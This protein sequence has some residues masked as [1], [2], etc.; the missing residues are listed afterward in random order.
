MLAKIRSSAVVG[1]DALPVTVEV[2]I[3]YGLPAFST[4]GLA[5]GAVRESRERVKAAIKNSGY[6]FP[7]RRITVNLAPA[8][9]KKEGAGYDLPMALGIL[10]ASE[11]LRSEKL[12]NYG[13]IGELSL[14]GSI[15]PAKGILPMAI[16]AQK[17]G[18]EG[19]LVPVANAEEAAVVAGI[20]TIGV[21]SLYEAVE[22]LAGIR[23]LSPTTVDLRTIFQNNAN[24]AIDFDEV[25]GQEHVKRAMEIAAA[26][27]HNILMKGPPGSGKTMMARRLPTILPDLTFEEALETT[28]I[29]SVMGML[30]NNNPL[31]AA[32]PFRA[33]HHTIS[34]A[35]LIGG[36][37]TPKPG[38]VSLAHNGV[39]FLDESP[40]F[41]KNVLEVLRQPLED[42]TVTISRATGSLSFPSRFILVIAFNPCP[43]GYL[44]DIKHNCRCTPAQVQRYE[45][46]LS[47]PLLDRIDMHLE[48]PAVPY[49]EMASGN[50]GESSSVIKERVEQAR[51]VQKKRFAKRKNFYCNG[52]MT[53]KDLKKICPLDKTSEKL[54]AESVE[55]LGLSAR[56]YHRILK[57]GRTIADLDRN[58]RLQPKYIA[59]AIQYR[60]LDRG[61]RY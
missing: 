31:L 50:S 10:T 32:R 9:V 38:E 33:P 54:I 4:V 16:A 44:G 14:D 55:R 18:L 11:I 21:K 43:C 25:K 7:N 61:N 48:V 27:G 40:E 46:R 34:D 26:G 41:K 36:G 30:K 39:L 37:Q 6:D 24:Y 2:D 15:R 58:E 5:E 28:K 56:S 59:E 57:I 3:S 19:I 49:K 29:Y 60:R 45:S 23:E 42:A 53:P 12:E 20:K 17:A 52:Q 22:F 35:G 1:V 47:G 51:A 8:D 13:V